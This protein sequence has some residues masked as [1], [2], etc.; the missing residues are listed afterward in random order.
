MFQFKIDG[1]KTS[2]N[3]YSPEK[4]LDAMD[5]D[6][7]DLNIDLPHEISTLDMRR[8]MTALY[9]SM[10]E[11]GLVSYATLMAR[12]RTDSDMFD[13]SMIQVNFKIFNDYLQSVVDDY[14][15]MLLLFPD[16]YTI[17]SR[18]DAAKQNLQEMNNV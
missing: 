8:P 13:M 18:L 2:V 15:A 10:Y 4:I 5:N 3:D 9:N 16:N 14:D 11:F 12:V 17:Q 1:D 6:H 7:I